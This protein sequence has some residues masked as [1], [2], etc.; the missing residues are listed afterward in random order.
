LAGAA[1]ASVVK[2]GEE[3]KAARANIRISLFMEVFLK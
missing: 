1:E 2:S 3:A